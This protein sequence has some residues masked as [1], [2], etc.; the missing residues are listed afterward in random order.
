MKPRT[1][2][3][4]RRSTAAAA[5]SWGL[6]A[7][8]AAFYA[9][10]SGGKGLSLPLDFSFVTGS[11]F[12]LSVTP[13]ASAAGVE[14]GDRVLTIDG[15]SAIHIVRSPFA[16]QPG[17]A[18]RYRLEKPD[19][20]VIEI[21]L[22]PVSSADTV[23]AYDGLLHV[24][25]LS[26]ATLYIV[27][28]ALVWW[29]KPDR[30]E[31]WSLFLF[32]CT[33]SVL[34]SS[35]VRADLDPWSGARAIA[36]LPWLGAT[37]FH[38]FTTYPIQPRWLESRGWFRAVPYGI[39]VATSVAIFVVTNL[40][41]SFEWPEQAAFYIG[42][43]MS[44]ASMAILA[45]ERRRANRAGLG[46]RADLML[47]AGLVSFLPGVVVAVMPLF[48][49]VSFPWYAAL[50]SMVFFPLAVSYGMVRKQLFDF[51]L[52]AR[53]SATYGV[54]S[55]V[56]TGGFA[57]LVTFTDEIVL[58]SGVTA[59]WIQI[60]ALFLAILA[61]NPVRAR[62]Q[63]IVDRFFDRDRARYRAA[64]GEVAEALVSVSSLSEVRERILTVLTEV[65]GVR[66]AMLM[67]IDAD[68]ERVVPGAWGGDWADPSDT[69]S[70][71]R[72]HPVVR[73]L[74]SGFEE[75]AR[76]DFDDEPDVLQRNLCLEVFDSQGIEL[77]VPISF[78]NELLGVIAVGPKANGDRIG[79]A[80]R[81]LLR[82]LA[83]QSAIGL[84]NAKAFEEIAQLNENLEERVEERTRELRKIE[85]QLIQSEKMK[86]LGQLVAGVA[87]EL[88]NPIGFVHA[89]LQ[90]L[91]EYVAE[92]LREGASP[93]EVEHARNAI[94]RLLARSRE[95]TERV[96]D[97]VQELRTFSRMD[98]TALQKA[99]L[100]EELDR[101]LTLMKP[102]LRGAVKLVRD[103]EPL[104]A[105]RCYPG[106]LNQVFLNLLIN[107]CDAMPEGG[108]ITVRS[109][110]LGDG[111]RMEVAD[112]GSGIPQKLL[113]QIF[114]PFFTTKGVGKGTGLGLSTSHDIIERHG[115]RISATSKPSGG[116]IFAIELPLD[117]GEAA[118]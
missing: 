54:A 32:S 3:F 53:S 43:F 51:R 13:S 87:H 22:T 23:R 108:T 40:G 20:R 21:A 67:F 81:Q 110:A 115:G 106:Q 92:L 112:S 37:A 91:D 105:V 12:V 97:I 49:A 11:A 29:G 8:G 14:P 57:L 34:L 31:T 84:E 61:F 85:A 24:G 38:L 104:P 103:Y 64:V 70:L 15:S 77:L 79:M 88:N 76:I 48:I 69:L 89:N 30:D 55:L 66:R 111:V 82:T 109:R 113:S 35:G 36:V 95:G 6:L 80:D 16:L 1:T 101:T 2:R 65:M 58:L 116:A 39:A 42:V 26:L 4:F 72:K 73:S 19:G 102:R 7:I 46:E 96:K 56:V 10:S 78:E 60:V 99:D 94:S 86:S 68:S 118:Q 45:T 18:H 33:A 74:E 62:I 63:K 27:I 47:A 71:A 9:I 83:N 90:L 114:D 98:Q 5:V 100:N 28:A 50:L 117:A 17:V 25:L 59:R 93:K 107:A 41:I 44:V 52:A 75:R